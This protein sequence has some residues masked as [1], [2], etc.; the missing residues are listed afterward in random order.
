[1]SEHLEDSFPDDTFADVLAG[2][3]S[4]AETFPGTGLTGRALKLGMAL[5]GSKKA[6]KEL[7]GSQALDLAISTFS[8]EDM[9]ALGDLQTRAKLKKELVAKVT[10]GYP[11]GEVIDVYFTEFVMQ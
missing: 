4:Y 11:E 8:G 5:Q 2:N 10:E 9:A 6:G 7:D 3:A 1:V